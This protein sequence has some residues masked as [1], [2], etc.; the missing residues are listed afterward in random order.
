MQSWTAWDWAGALATVAGLAGSLAGLQPP[1]QAETPAVAL[2]QAGELEFGTRRDEVVPLPATVREELVGDDRTDLVS[3]GVAR[4]V[5]TA[6]V[7]QV[8]R[9]RV[10]AARRERAAEDV[11]LRYVV[12]AGVGG[13]P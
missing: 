11:L 3:A 6:P 4:E 13:H 7:A 1:R 8:A 9:L 2:G 5:P 10:A 12:V